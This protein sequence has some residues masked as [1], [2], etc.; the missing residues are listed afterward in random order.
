MDDIPF[1]KR[2]WF[3]ITSWLVF[4]V[5]VYF[6]QIRQM[7]GIQAN[8][9][10]V[11]TDLFCI[12][13]I[14][15]LFWMAFFSQFV[16]PVN[17][18]RDRQKIFDRLLRHLTRSHGPA[19]FIK[20]GEIQEHSGERLRRGPGVVWLDSASAAVT[21]SAVAFKNVLGPGVHFTEPNEYIEKSGT[22]DL[23][24]QI[25][26]LGPKEGENPFVDLKD[27]QSKEQYEDIQNRRRQVSALSRDGIE[28]VPDISIMFRVNSGFPQGNE[29]GSRF[30]YRTGTTRFAK[31]QERQDQDVIARAILGE[32]V[33]PNIDPESNLHRVAWNRLPA[34][35]AVDIWREYAAKFTLDEIFYPGQLPPAPAAELPLPTADEIAQIKQPV[36]AG[37]I[38][39]KNQGLMAAMLR[40]INHSM[41]RVIN[42]LEKTNAFTPGAQAAASSSSKSNGNKTVAAK[43]ALQVINDMVKARLTQ[44]FVDVLD[45]SGKW[46]IG[47]IESEEYKLL[48][49]RGLKVLSVSISNVRLHPSVQEQWLRQWGAN[50]LLLAKR[51]S[52]QLDRQ[53]NLTETAAQEEA[54]LNYALLLSREL[55]PL[56]RRGNP[57][58]RRL[59]MALLLRSRSI[60]RSGEYSN[61]LRR[62]MTVE[63]QEIED[64]IKWMGDI[65][66]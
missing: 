55:D 28:L 56:C 37:A 62:R 32:A 60:I 52:D 65:E 36:Q 38:Q 24:I 48:Q 12:F 33:N 4:L 11:F 50:W 27:T 49:S 3:Y 41:E 10:T 46:G 25:Q 30:G 43:T 66:K 42:T 40:D 29:P 64:T 15:L 53:R 34:M 9:N 54:Q 45:Q 26:K 5:I 63:L 19:L 2:P 18:F 61:S 21:R 16:L 8:Q 22:L 57:P 23:H 51:E 47:Q 20:D 13:P 7:G 35:L 58:I 31:D 6:W 1:Y 39:K 14:F 44:P 59:L 17:T